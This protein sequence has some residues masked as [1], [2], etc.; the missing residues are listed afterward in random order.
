MLMT[1]VALMTCRPTDILHHSFSFPS[2]H[3]N[4][5][6]VSTGFLLFALLPA[7]AAH[8]TKDDESNDATEGDDGCAFYACPPAS[9]DAL[10]VSWM[11]GYLE[12][13]RECLNGCRLSVPSL[14]VSLLMHRGTVV[15][16]KLTEMRR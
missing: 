6:M 7:V 15:A 8:N 13:A 5:A 9:S 16:K 12:A 4:A 3:T 2:G 14:S 11:N 10:A 1:M